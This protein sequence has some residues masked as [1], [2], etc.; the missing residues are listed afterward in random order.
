MISSYISIPVPIERKLVSYSIHRRS[1]EGL[2][3][4]PLNTAAGSLLAKDEH[5]LDALFVAV[6]NARLKPIG[7]GQNTADVVFALGEVIAIGSA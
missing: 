2:Q 3:V 4:E 1:A 6:E 7:C 5:Q